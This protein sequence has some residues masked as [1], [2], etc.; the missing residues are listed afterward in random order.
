MIKFLK[1]CVV[2]AG[3]CVVVAHW[4]VAASVLVSSAKVSWVVFASG[5]LAFASYSPGVVSTLDVCGYLN[6]DLET[7]RALER[8]LFLPLVVWIFLAEAILIL[9]ACGLIGKETGLS[10]VA[11]WVPPLWSFLITVLVFA[12]LPS[13][14][15]G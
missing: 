12:V 7:S 3:L 14:G 13:G 1:G 10:V 8:T 5:L 2:A 9:G 4:L 6:L 11:A 15:R